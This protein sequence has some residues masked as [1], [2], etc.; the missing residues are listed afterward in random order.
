V[1]YIVVSV[2]CLLA[3][4]WFLWRDKKIQDNTSKQKANKAEVKNFFR[5]AAVGIAVCALTWLLVLL[6]GM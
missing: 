4:V 6:T 2:L 1:V 5:F 3:A